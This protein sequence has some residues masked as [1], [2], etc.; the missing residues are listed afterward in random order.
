VIRPELGLAGA[1]VL[2]RRDTAAGT[3]LS[4]VPWRSFVQG[5]VKQLQVANL[6]DA[7]GNTVHA[8]GA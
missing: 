2:A 8:P 1:R 4:A 3:E 6:G 7:D 5:P